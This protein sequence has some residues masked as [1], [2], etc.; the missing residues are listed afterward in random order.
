VFDGDEIAVANFP[1]DTLH[2]F[3]TS[4]EPK[5]HMPLGGVRPSSLAADPA[6][7][8][9]IYDDNDEKAQIFGA[10]VLR[11]DRSGTVRWRSARLIIMDAALAGDG[12]VWTMTRTDKGSVAILHYADP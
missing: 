1:D 6:G 7:Y 2:V 10:R 3:D 11:W 12:S 8:L 9:M 5:R 4:G